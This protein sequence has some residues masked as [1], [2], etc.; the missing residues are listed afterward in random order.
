MR[1]GR[2]VA[3]STLG[4]SAVSGQSEGEGHVSWSLRSPLRDTPTDAFPMPYLRQCTSFLIA[5]LAVLVF[6]VPTS[7]Q[8]VI[9]LT[10]ERMVELTMQNSF[11]IQ[12]VDLDLQRTRYNLQ[13]EQARLKSQVDLRLQLPTINVQSEAEFDASLGRNIIARE[14]SQRWQ[15]DL[16]ISQPVILFGY[17]TGGEL[18]VNSRVYQYKQVDNEGDIFNQYYNRYFLQYEHG[19]F[20]PNELKNDLEQA[21]LDVEE[22]QLEYQE[23]LIDVINSVAYT[24]LGIFGQAYELEIE[25]GY[26]ERL[27]TALALAEDLADEDP[28]RESDVEQ[29]TI[30]LANAEQELQQTRAEFRR[31][32]VEIKQDLR[33]S[34]MDS[35][36]ILDPQL[37]IN[38]VEF[39]TELAIGRAR[40]LT[41][42]LRNIQINYRKSEIGLQE[43]EG[44]SGFRMDLEFTYGREMRDEVWNDLFGEPEDSYSV[45]IDAN[46]PIWD[47][48]ARDARIQSRR[49]GLEQTRLRMEEEQLEIDADIANQ[50]TSLEENESRV[51]SMSNNF[52]LA[53]T[54]TDRALDR[55]GSGTIGI[56][57]LLQALDREQETHENMLDA[58]SAWRRGLINLRGA[59]WWDWERNMP[60]LEG[61]GISV[62]DDLDFDTDE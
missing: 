35:L 31:R 6:S 2:G 24:Y 39:D 8:Q 12:R 61:F 28:E 3:R 13:A 42:R 25:R 38:P 51:F 10:L 23:D 62:A 41:P 58:Y 32:S 57:E 53:Q 34:P 16:S 18:S 45:S 44:R 7:A 52:E 22:S 4:P 1:V 29:I 20:Q 9:D 60:A 36:V 14:N 30:E 21:Q 49:I 37:D 26:I 46:L 33:L 54:S 48:G 50:I 15:A 17:P 40:E 47:W 55:Y 59:T 11:R 56:L 43:Y 5:A 27:R 19:L